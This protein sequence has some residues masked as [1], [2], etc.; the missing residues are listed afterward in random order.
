VKLSES[1]NYALPSFGGPPNALSF[2]M[3]SWLREA[4]RWKVDSALR[5]L[6]VHVS[7]RELA[8][9][10]I[11]AILAREAARVAAPGLA[12]QARRERERDFC[13]RALE[14]AEQA[15]EGARLELA[16]REA[17]GE[18][19]R[20]AL[21]KAGAERF[22]LALEGLARDVAY[23]PTADA[24]EAARGALSAAERTLASDLPPYAYGYADAFAPA[25]VEVLQT[26]LRAKCAARDARVAALRA[27]LAD[28]QASK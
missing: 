3:P 5:D 20:A 1:T 26:V 6:G 12:E 13:A 11:E 10:A 2:E 9:P 14:A 4:E 28:L 7:P 19:L 27:D 24:L 18:K 8:I 23:D 21:T 16:E 17:A 25:A 22:S 15:Y